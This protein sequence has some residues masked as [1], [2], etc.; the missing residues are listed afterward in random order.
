MQLNTEI[1]AIEADRLAQ[2]PAV[3]VLEA[4]TKELNQEIQVLNKQHGAINTDIRAL[5]QAGQAVAVEVWLN[6]FAST[7]YPLISAS[8]NIDCIHRS[9]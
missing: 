6:P 3:Q 2:Q 9:S 1:E 5:K 7:S 8:L 4:E